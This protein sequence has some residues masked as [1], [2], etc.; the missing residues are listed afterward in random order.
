[1]SGPQASW[2][3]LAILRWTTDYFGAKGVPEPRASAEIL[4]A[5]TLGVSR[6]D[7]YLRYDQPLNADELA[8][9]KALM[10]RRRDGEPVAYLTGH[11]EFWSLDIQ[12]TPAVLIPRPETETLVAAALEAAKDFGEE[13]AGAGLKPAPTT[14]WGLE[15][16]VG[17]GA[18]VIALAKELPRMSWVG[19][20]RS[21]RGPHRGPGQCPAAWG[22]RPRPLPPVGPFGRAQAHRGLCP[23]GGQSALCAP[24]GV[25]T[26]PPGDQGV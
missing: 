4:L 24:G 22:R 3:I 9:F 11:R 21:G 15:V 12:V 25:G 23:A 2:T 18:V 26:A 7:L 20:D 17:S 16:G 6:L 8:R 5:H 13:D 19:L 14:P 1:M 10:V